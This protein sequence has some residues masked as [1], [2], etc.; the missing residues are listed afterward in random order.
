M[1]NDFNDIRKRLDTPILVTESNKIPKTFSLY[2]AITGVKQGDN[3][4]EAKLYKANINVR[5]KTVRKFITENLDKSSKKSILPGQMILF[6]YFEPQTKE[7]LE[8]YDAKP[9]TIFFGKFQTEDGERVIGFNIHY[10]P[11]KLRYQIMS[12]IFEIF[13]PIY[14][15]NWNKVLESEVDAFDYKT[16]I[17]LLQRNDLGFGIRM[18]IPS[19]MNNIIP[20][21]SKYFQKI[22]FTEGYFKKR[23]R[24]QILNYWKNWSKKHSK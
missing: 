21:P 13:R 16:L 6:D 20:I 23:T 2:K 14:E 7:D 17:K 9:C 1:A 24:E 11:P 12:R 18:Y 15:K 10:Y 3:D 5:D 19:L 4:G 8:Y 22:V